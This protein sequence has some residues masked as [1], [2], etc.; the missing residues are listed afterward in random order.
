LFAR[1]AAYPQAFT[2]GR[3]LPVNLQPNFNAAARL[4]NI[5]VARQWTH[6]N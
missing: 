5:A 2:S 4:L 1:D 3:L 6:G